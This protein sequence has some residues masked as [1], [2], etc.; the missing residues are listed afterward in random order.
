MMIDALPGDIFHR[1]QI[2]NNTYEIE[3]VLGRGGTGEVYRAKN[4][5]SGRIVAVKALNALLSGKAGYIELM[6]REEQMRD[7]RDDA[8]VRYT[9]CSRMEQGHVFLVMD[10]IAGPSIADEMLQ[11][12]LEP[13]ELMIIAHR[14]AE[15]LVAAHAIGIVHRDLSPDNII[16]RDGS[17]EKA[18]IID[19]G[20]AKDSA[21]GARTIVGNDFA[22]KYEYAAPEQMEGKAER[23]SDLYALGALLLAAW[24]GQVPFAGMTPGEIIR[25]KQEPLDSAGVPEP[26]KGL[27]DWLAHP[28]LAQRAPSA[29]AVVD[30]LGKVLKGGG[31]DRDRS[32]LTGAPPRTRPDL[33]PGGEQSR[34]EGGRKWLVFSL[35]AIVLAGG[36]GAWSM[37]VLPGAGAG[38][39]GLFAPPL[40][41][42]APY[43]LEAVAAG[44]LTPAS[45]RADAPD[46]AA[47]E[48]IRAGF[49][50][51]SGQTALPEAVTLAEGMPDPAWAV[52]AASVFAA[53][54]GLQDWQIKLED[55]TA[56]ISGIAS[57]P[58]AA[59]QRRASL[60]Q[61]AISHEIS[62]KS[63]IIAGPKV[64]SLAS[65]EAVLESLQTC[66][67]PE[68]L[69]P[70]AQG[71]PLGAVLT[72]SG[73][74]A[75][76][77][78]AATLTEALQPIVGDRKLQISLNVLNPHLCRV[79]H[80]MPDL[81][82]N[83]VSIWMG[84]GATNEANLSGIYSAGDNPVVDVLI[85]SNV[86][87]GQLWA[88]VVDTDGGVFHLLPNAN[89][90]A[91]D[92][93]K[94]GVIEGGTRRVRLIHSFNEKL[95]DPQRL[96]ME[97]KPDDFGKSEFIAF[98]TIDNMFNTRRPTEES[99]ESFAA[100]LEEVQRARPGNI[101]GF[102][103]RILESR[104]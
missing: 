68:L 21:V 91:N 81:P 34:A 36:A 50:Q 3:G 103:T 60:D 69:D 30:Q 4:L 51:L 29:Q 35:I 89:S 41:L 49:N 65:I 70:P 61:W 39:S 25:R 58:E 19:F 66:G 16:L 94:L 27:I 8:V 62:L 42:A 45:L 85:P 33:R 24:K 13:R 14:V 84:Q 90:T 6:R 5:I 72:I 97:V 57:T 55:M 12:R 73:F 37:G 18:T 76:A 93:S 2:L 96:A 7:I 86:T 38:V 101:F 67:T 22:G 87:K 64:L 74:A 53:A 80:A 102:A 20:I 75:D 78:L 82:N 71:F 92:I 54:E 32:A 52:A 40:P 11:R 95:A 10:Y 100:A 43:R 31:G 23:R 59:S 83:A 9:E 79:R 104:P 17:P 44:G 26:L 15:G 56:E 28:A 63:N 77:S 48:A 46:A 47:A 1:G 88:M 99:V 98:L